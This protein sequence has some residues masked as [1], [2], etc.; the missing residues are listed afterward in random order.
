MALKECKR[1][2]VR[3]EGT[4]QEGRLGEKCTTFYHLLCCN[5][6]S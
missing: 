2:N 3:D 6:L 1:K 5:S 4:C